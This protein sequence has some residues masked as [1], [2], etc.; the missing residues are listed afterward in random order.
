LHPGPKIFPKIEFDP[1]IIRERL[2]TVSYIHKGVRVVFENEAEKTKEGFQHHEGLRHFP[3]KIVKD[4]GQKVVHDA[5]FTLE[6]DSGPRLDLVLQWTEST[7]E[8]IR[9]Y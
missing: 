6:R 9:S 2:E 3:A 1:A 8:H 5:A 7:D 4:R